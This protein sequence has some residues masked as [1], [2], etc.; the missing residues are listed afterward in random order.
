MR[1]TSIDEIVET[2]TEEEK[3]KF[4]DLIE[5]CKEREDLIKKSTKNSLI[6]LEKLE[7]LLEAQ[8]K[9]DQALKKLELTASRIVCGWKVVE[10]KKLMN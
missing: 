7:L 3:S 10:K 9:V 6:A 5:E 1:E 2:L 4:K 8:V